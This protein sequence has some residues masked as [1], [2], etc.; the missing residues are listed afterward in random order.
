MKWLLIQALL[1]TVAGC[2]ILL[3][4]RIV[5]KRL[6]PSTVTFLWILFFVCALFPV[7]LMKEVSFYPAQEETVRRNGTE[8]ERW[9]VYEIDRSQNLTAKMQKEKN[10]KLWITTVWGIGALCSIIYCVAVRLKIRK[11]VRELVST[12]LREELP[13]ESEFMR[14]PVMVTEKFG[15]VVYGFPPTIYIPKE[16]L[17]DREML[18]SILLHEQA[19]VK[20]RHPAVLV[21]ME[22]VGSLYW[23]LPYVNFM[24][25]RALR[26]DMEYRCDYE[27]IHGHDV[28]PK[29]YAMHY[30]NVAAYGHMA[31]NELGFGKGGM[32]KRVDYMLHTAK[33]RKYSVLV[34]VLGMVLLAGGIIGIN[35]YYHK[36]DVNGHSR[37]EVEEAKEVVMRYVACLEN[38]DRQGVLDC[39]NAPDTQS[40]DYAMEWLRFTVHDLRYEPD[41]IVNYYQIDDMNQKNI[42]SSNWVLLVMDCDL[43]TRYDT[44]TMV[45]WWTLVRENESEPWKILQF[46]IP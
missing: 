39:L 3:V 33:S 17:S 37:A 14:I 30:V 35:A 42:E 4:R 36:P 26:E 7:C 9:T 16:L 45:I 5:G 29:E 13:V 38:G 8:Y 1:V 19:H 22:F 2:V 44:D 15:P 27:V 24:F 12:D 43:K 23:F 18:R 46:G 10:L 28:S 41:S 34:A 6:L 20:R 40:I 31:G 32:K 21:L 11:K 25:F